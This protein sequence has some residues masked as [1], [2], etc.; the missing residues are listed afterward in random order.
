M[1]EEVLKRLSWEEFDQSPGKYWREFAEVRRFRE[2]AELIE[3]YLSLHPELESV[4]ASTLY[5]HAGHCRAMGGDTDEA[6]RLMSLALHQTESSSETTSAGLLWNE[7]VTGTVCF[8]QQYRHGLELA[9]A[10]LALSDPVNLPNLQILDR[11]IAH[12][13]KPYAEAYETEG[14]DHRKLSADSF[15]RTWELLDKEK[16]SQ[17]EDERMISF[18]HASLA[19]WR[20]REDCTDQN[21]SIGYW[22]ISRVYAVLGDGENAKRYGELCLAVSGKEPPF[23]LGYAHEAL[24]R[25]FVVQKDR[26][27]FDRHLAEARTQATL[28]TDPEERKFL[29]GDLAGLSWR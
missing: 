28:V 22:Q 14:Q 5:F 24:A 12:F 7:Y 29:E 21:L 13:G 3:H 4:N 6:I 11:L 9:H 27:A 18:A 2:A 15:N 25:A 16:R 26:A 10:T 19:H 17:E 1:N 23:Y 8:L 20:M